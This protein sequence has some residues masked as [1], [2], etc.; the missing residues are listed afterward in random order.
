MGC[1]LCEDGGAF[2]LRIDG[3]WVHQGRFSGEGGRRGRHSDDFVEL[4]EDLTGLYRA[5]P[6]ATW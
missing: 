2:L 5:H 4:W 3:R 6:G 1:T